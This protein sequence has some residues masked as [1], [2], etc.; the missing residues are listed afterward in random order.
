M[1]GAAA[2][3]DA[4]ARPRIGIVVEAS[5]DALADAVAAR[6]ATLAMLRRLPRARIEVLTTGDAGLPSPLDCG[7]PPR[8]LAKGGR[9]RQRLDLMAVVGAAD[10]SGRATRGACPVVRVAASA[11]DVALLARAA[12]GDEL[13]ANRLGVMRL[14]G[15][16]PP[17]GAGAEAVELPPEA[18]VDER[19]AAAVARGSAGGDERSGEITAIS[20]TF[21]TAAAAALDCWHGRGSPGAIADPA[22][23]RREGAANAALRVEIRRLERELEALSLHTNHVETELRRTLD[24]K[25]WRY[26]EGARDLYRAARRRL[27]RR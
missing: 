5:T 10:V 22:P 2:P 13:L 9:E 18:G 12:M 3:L 1:T 19:I 26:T 7:R 4:L 27:R 14:L 15:W 16:L 6:V 24:S 17:E 23:S 8:V 25:S 20:A 21:D 11:A